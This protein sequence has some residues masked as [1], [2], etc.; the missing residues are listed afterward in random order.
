MIRYYY[1]IIAILF[2]LSISNIAIAAEETE[3]DPAIINAIDSVL[4]EYENGTL[5]EDGQE[6]NYYIDT[7]LKEEAGNKCNASFHCSDVMEA[8]L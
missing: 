1:T 3:I 4:Q 2:S 7:G 5:T 8:N 6:T